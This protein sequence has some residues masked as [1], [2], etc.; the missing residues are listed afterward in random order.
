MRIRQLRQLAILGSLGTVAVATPLRAQSGSSAVHAD[1]RHQGP[2]LVATGVTLG[3]MRFSGGRTEHAMSVLLLVRPLSW[4]QLSTAPGYARTNL[5]TTSAT[6][7]TDIPFG[8]MALH[9][10]Q[11]VTWSPSLSGGLSSTISPGHST[12]VL[13]LGQSAVEGSAGVGVSPTDELDLSL[14][15]SHPLTANS[16]NGSLSLESAS[17]FGRTTGSLGFSTE[18]GRAD[19]AA[20]L[21]RSVAAGVAYSLSGPLTLT[22][23]ASHGLTSG[24]PVW[25]LSVG[26]G[27]AFAGVSPLGPNSALKRLKNAL[28]AKAVSTSGYSKTASGASACKK[29]GTC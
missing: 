28:G 13:G 5:G 9:S 17:S 12:A 8:A 11:D 4:L 21:S 27:T 10:F 22:V 7:L 26:M 29:A 15:G 16:G 1:E 25:T 18:I 23:D 3:A 19:S 6:G 14:S 2:P 20:V 24:A